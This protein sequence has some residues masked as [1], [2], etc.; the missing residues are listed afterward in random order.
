[1]TLI[2]VVDDEFSI[3][4]ML[5]AVLEEEGYEVMTASNGQEGLRLL[6][7]TLPALV[8]S[9]IMMPILDGLELCRRMQADGRLKFIPVVL[10]SAA[11][12]TS[13]LKECK[14][15]AL[16]KKPFGLSEMLQMVAR[17]VKFNGSP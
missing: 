4:E 10:M 13:Y 8:I 1:M 7:N 3:V 12:T 17:L 15:A 14:Y 16:L 11:R 2:L 6:Q 5:S 9:D